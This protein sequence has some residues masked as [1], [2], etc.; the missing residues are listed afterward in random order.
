MI[1][2]YHTD[3]RLAIYRISWY[4]YK[5]LNEMKK[6]ILFLAAAI[7]MVFLF[8]SDSYAQKSKDSIYV[9]KGY[10]YVKSKVFEGKI[11]TSGYETH[12]RYYKDK[13][14][15][16]VF[17][18]YANHPDSVS[19]SCKL[20]IRDKIKQTRT[21]ITIS[22]FRKSKNLFYVKDADHDIPKA[23]RKII[24]FLENREN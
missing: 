8:S 1:Q 21:E 12:I 20:Y 18:S 14:V 3:S 4:F 11:V 23:L 7:L 10:T 19:F 15:S 9:A 13:S 22:I 5:N 6:C 17:N 16:L 24:A 2:V